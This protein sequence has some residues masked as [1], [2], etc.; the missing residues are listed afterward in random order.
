MNYNTTGCITI[1]YNKNLIQRIVLHRSA[2]LLQTFL[3]PPSSV[4]RICNHGKILTINLSKWSYWSFQHDKIMFEW[5]Q[6]LLVCKKFNWKNFFTNGDK[7]ITSGQILAFEV[8]IR[9]YQSARHDGIICKWLQC[10]LSCQNW[11]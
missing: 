8:S 10:L 4:Y 2:I 7:I 6:C 1:Q 3:W 9:P 11:N 5:H